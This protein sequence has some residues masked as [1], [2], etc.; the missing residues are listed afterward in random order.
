LAAA[1]VQWLA[2][3]LPPSIPR[4]HEIALNGTVVAFTAAIALLATLFFGIVPALR[5]TRLAA[6]SA[7]S[8]GTRSTAGLSHH[9]LSGLLVAGEMAL[10]VML[11]IGATLL[12]RSFQELRAVDP[13]FEPARVI[14]ARLTPPAAEYRDPARTTALYAGVLERVGALPGVQSVGAVDRLPIAQP[15]YGT[16]VR[17]EGQFEDATR[18]LPDVPHMQQVT[19]DYFATMGI[20]VLRG[21]GFTDA[22]REGQQPVAIVS[23]SVARRFWPGEDA[24]GRRIGYPWESPW[25]SIIGVVPDNRQDS[26]TDTLAGTIYVAWEQRT[27]VAGSEMWVV[28][29]ATTDPGSLA[30]AIRRVVREAD[31]SVPVSDVRTMDAVIADSLTRV[32]FT[33]LLVGAFALT[34]LTLGALGIY[35]VM[36]YLVSQRTQEIGVRIALGAPPRQ[37]VG[38]VLSRAVGLA[39][40]GAAGGIIAAIAATRPLQ[41]FLYGISATDPL[42]FALVPLLFLVVAAGA[43][44]APARRATRVDP[45]RALRAN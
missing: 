27:R 23:E 3:A 7:S 37:V 43:S 40:A 31:R 36:A 38:L 41:S 8:G 9:R 26:L 17:V 21:R 19:P 39:A 28:A 14:A 33:T 2:S 30:E 11:V 32:R 35:G 10:A 45:V 18:T 16:A 42:T 4:A 25:L 5:A 24:T 1:V 34:A 22:D 13:G 6:A 44:Y 29:R 20:P 15:V 12:V